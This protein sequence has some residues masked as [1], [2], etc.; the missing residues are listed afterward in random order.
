MENKVKLVCSNPWCK[1]Q[2]TP[3]PLNIKEV[4]G[5]KVY[6]KTCYKCDSFNDDM[7]SGVE[8]E[9]REYEKDINDLFEKQEIN[10][11]VT[12]YRR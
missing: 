1:A 3:R 10:Y 8:W 12:N 6:P 7:S 9:D 11:K 5:K 2:F 4:N